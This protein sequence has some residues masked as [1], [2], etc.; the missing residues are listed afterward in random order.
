MFRVVYV[1]Y[2][3]LTFF[4]PGSFCKQC[5]FQMYYNNDP[6]VMI[7]ESYCFLNE[8]TIL[9]M[10]SNASFNIINNTGGWIMATNGTFS[11]TISTNGSIRNCSLYGGI[12]NS[13]KNLVLWRFSF[14]IILYFIVLIA[15]TANISIHFVY[16]EL[17]TVTGILII[18]FSISLAISMISAITY[19]LMSYHQQGNTAVCA[20][21]INYFSV[22]V[23]GLIYEATKAAILTH[24]A[25]SMY[26]CYKLLG[27]HEN[28]EES[29]LRKCIAFVIVVPTI[30]SIIIITVDVEVSRK[31]FNTVDGQCIRFFDTSASEGIPTSVII[32]YMI[33]A[34]W[35]S[36]ETLMV[37]I[38]FILYFLTTR[39]CCTA[40]KSK[41]FRVVIVL[42]AI[43]EL[44]IIVL[45]IFMF[46]HDS[47]VVELLCIIIVSATAF[48]QFALFMLFVS[49]SKVSCYCKH[50]LNLT[51]K[52]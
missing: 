40:T 44:D 20:I 7:M 36:V 21:L 10:E 19:N 1:T 18:I 17:R 5:D 51:V 28:E 16:K 41:D 11:F 26:K 39:Q 49:S 50:Y 14:L 34:I 33:L 12:E 24:F 48:A 3:I 25:H 32:Y 2:V 47:D 15:A 13:A 4:L 27:C 42:I 8:C 31:A 22:I 45:I 9:L 6:P 23:C 35:L 30:M 37:T 52:L 38:G 29:M 46:V 43:I